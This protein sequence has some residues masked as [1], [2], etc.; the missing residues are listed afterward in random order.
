MNLREKDFWQ[1]CNGITYGDAKLLLPKL[2]DKCID[3][4]LTDPPYDLDRFDQEWYHEQFE[5]LSKGWIIVF[6]SPENQWCGGTVR[7]A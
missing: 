7:H 4:V 2:P 5:R 3:T 6:G 1:Y